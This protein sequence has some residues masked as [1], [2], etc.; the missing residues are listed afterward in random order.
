MKSILKK[1]IPEFLLEARRKLLVN[2]PDKEYRKLPLNETFKIIYENQLWGKPEDSSELF[3]SGDGSHNPNITSI[4]I[5]EV[6]KFLKSFDSKLNAVD[7]GCGDFSIGSQLRVFCKDYVAC[8]VV[9]VLIKRNKAKFQ[10]LNVDFRIIDITTEVLP[11]GDVVFIRQVLQHLSNKQI[12]KV[13][14]KLRGKYKYLVLTEHLPLGSDFIPNLNKPAGP[15]IRLGIGQNG[16]GIILTKPPFNMI[17]LN[18]EIICEYIDGNSI[19]RTNVYTL[20]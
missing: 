11:D 16:S 9:D 14:Q 12:I 10:G 6:T 17:P 2:I 20:K 13:I 4:Y 8:D 5:K 15:S 18:E 3:C 19:I 1:I 7:L